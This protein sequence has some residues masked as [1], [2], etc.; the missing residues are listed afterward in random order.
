MIS[1]R[2]ATWWCARSGVNTKP[3]SMRVRRTDAVADTMRKLSTGKTV[4]CTGN[5]TGG[6]ECRP[7]GHQRI[8]TGRRRRW[9]GWGST[10]E[11]NALGSAW[12]TSERTTGERSERLANAV[13][14]H[15]KSALG[16]S[17]G[18]DA[19]R[20]RAR[21]RRGGDGVQNV[22]EGATRAR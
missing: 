15:A 5:S 1:G 2:Q 13:A 16:G 9:R 12:C 7:R 20:G 19:T 6:A 17:G 3:L 10:R 14:G 18:M 11:V 4:R 22:R 8:R 21:T